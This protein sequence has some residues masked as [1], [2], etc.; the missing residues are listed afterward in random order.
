MNEDELKA[1]VDELKAE[2][3]SLANKNKELLSEVKKERTKSREIDAD[4]YYAMIDELESVKTENAKLNGEI[5]LK[6]KDTEKLMAQLGEK[7]GALQ[8]L[9]IDDGLTNALTSAGVV[10]ELM[11]AVKALLRSQTQLKDNQA[12]IGDKPLTDFM[13]EWATGEGKVYIKAPDNSGG[14]AGGGKQGDGSKDTPQT[15]KEMQKA[16]FTK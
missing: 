13:S 12:V 6:A 11:P 16:F 7:D 15:F 5:K 8:K 10:P 3:E 14:G 4:K 2:K 9:I 1:L